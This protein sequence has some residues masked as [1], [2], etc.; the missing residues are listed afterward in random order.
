MDPGAAGTVGF[1]MFKGGA[2][3]FAMMVMA[4][5]V[6]RVISLWIDHSLTSSEAT[7][8][9]TALLFLFLG[10]IIGWGT[11]VGWLLLIALIIGCL[12]LPI[13]N[14]MA[15][16]LALRKIEDADIRQFSE[17]LREQPRNT[18]L[19]ERLSRIFLSRGEWDL[20][21]AHVKQALDISPEDPGFKRLRERIET[22]QRRAEQRIKLCPKCFAENAAE[23]GAC[24][25]C[26]FRFTDPA[27]L[28]RTLWSRPALEAAKWTGL[29]MLFT[30]LLVLILGVS[31]LAAG[32][33]MMMGI[34]SLFW[35][36]YAYFTRRGPKG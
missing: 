20:A 4:Y 35:Y 23:A 12:G 27:D 13:I 10:I 9:L 17:T 7:L 28:L 16:K 3:V 11:P 29:G 18:Y 2:I 34:G 32:L 5:P 26:G 24:L 19:H 36:M 30:G 22:E 25:R 21:M 15:D 33:L 6:Y 8:Y 31:L 1:A 14:G